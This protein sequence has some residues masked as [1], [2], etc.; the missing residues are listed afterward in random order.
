MKKET[1]QRIGI[2]CLGIP[3]SVLAA[4]VGGGLTE[5]AIHFCKFGMREPFLIGWSG[6]FI[7]GGVYGTLIAAPA[8]LTMIVFHVCRRTVLGRHAF[9][10]TVISSLLTSFVVVMPP[11]LWQN[12]EESYSGLLVVACVVIVV[13]FEMLMRKRLQVQNA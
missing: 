12:N 7:A 6:D 13:V 2:A 8:L 10:T 9:V 3:L 4:F 1:K 5:W 11:H